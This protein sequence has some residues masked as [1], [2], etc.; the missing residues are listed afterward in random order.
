[1][2]LIQVRDVRDGSWP[3]AHWFLKEN[4]SWQWWAHELCSGASDEHIARDTCTNLNYC[5]AL[6][7]WVFNFVNFVNF[8][9]FT[10][11]F[12]RKFGQQQ[13]GNVSSAHVRKIIST[14][15]QK[16]DINKKLDPWNISALRYLLTC[17]LS[18]HLQMQHN[19]PFGQSPP[20]GHGQS[21]V[22]RDRGMETH[23]GRG[24]RVVVGG[25]WCPD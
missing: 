8:E 23:C 16:T 6:I 15:F 3:P 24:S 4:Q 9:S 5:I 2:S 25:I 1:M 17:V 20:L 21:Y 18:G 19:I 13:F 22:Q 7:S 12:Q 14:K 11:F 10:K